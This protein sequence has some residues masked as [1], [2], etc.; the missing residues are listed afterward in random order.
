[1]AL[2]K[3]KICLFDPILKKYTT[4][5]FL[6][7]ICSLNTLPVTTE[8]EV[9]KVLISTAASSFMI[10]PPEFI[11][12]TVSTTLLNFLIIVSGV[13]PSE[14]SF[15]PIC[16]TTASALHIKAGWSWDMFIRVFSTEDSLPLTWLLIVMS[17]ERSW[18]FVPAQN[19]SE[20]IIRWKQVFFL[21][22]LLFLLGAGGAPVFVD[23]KS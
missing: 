11:F 6:F 4:R 17:S 1:M 5:R 3:L 8:V 21:P 19:T 22:L 7:K 23:K 9:F 2:W 15:V 13:S 18:H 16:S 10:L 14:R 12:L 20:I